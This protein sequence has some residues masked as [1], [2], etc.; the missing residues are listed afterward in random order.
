M[1]I[2]ITGGL[3]HIGSYL[4]RNFPKNYNI[5]V[6][7]NL[8]TDRYCSLFN[9][10]KNITFI[11]SDIEDI[12]KSDLDNI[13]C[14]IH[15]AAITSVE[16]SISNVGEMESINIDKTKKFIDVCG[17]SKI[18]KFIFPSSSSVYGV[19]SEIV[20]ESS[21]FVNPQSPY[22]EAKYEIEKYITDKFSSEY[23]DYLILRFGTI[24]GFSEGMR[25]HTAI[26]K[27]CLQTS[28]GTPLTIWKQNYNQSRPYLGLNDACKCLLH[29]IEGDD[30]IWNDVYNVQ[31]LNI[32]LKDIVS[33]IEKI[34]G[35][36]IKLEMVDT[37][38]KNQFSYIVSDDKV[39]NTKFI[40]RDD[41][42]SNIINMMDIL[43]GL[44]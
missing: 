13:D 22:A 38:L 44:S 26:N 15:L 16:Q 1:N 12:S 17:D 40:P 42:H 7:D 25:F 18:S 39:R 8:L 34:Y 29:F 27:F 28:I 36:K 23:L 11:K 41:L 4:I 30:S 31:S 20:N 9:L 24:F 10:N 21:V 43:G 3:G 32:K 33:M 35:K 2:L 5:T 14:V 6:V 37:P 19:D